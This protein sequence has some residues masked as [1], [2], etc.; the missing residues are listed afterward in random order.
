MEYLALIHHNTDTSPTS[1]EWQEFFVLAQ[2]SG[3][4]RGGSEIGSRLVLG[5]KVVH[6]TT[7]SVVGYMRFD[8]ESL[9]PLL[10]LLEKHP[11]TLHGGTIELCELPK[12]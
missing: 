8:S 2:A 7:Q 11:V 5:G 4:F 6:D 10:Q 1:A 3:L 12:S 9:P